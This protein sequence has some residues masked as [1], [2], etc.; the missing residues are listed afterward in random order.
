MGFRVCVKVFD[1]AAPFCAGI[2]S[3]AFL[4]IYAGINETPECTEVIVNLFVIIVSFTNK[5]D[6]RDSQGGFKEVISLRQRKPVGGQLIDFILN[7]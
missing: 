7:P 5:T 6:N 2:L 4:N 1:C 3:A